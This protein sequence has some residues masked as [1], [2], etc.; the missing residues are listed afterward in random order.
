MQAA[1]AP[2][3]L[4]AGQQEWLFGTCSWKL[5]VLSFLF[6]ECSSWS[7]L[8]AMWRQGWFHISLQDCC[9]II[10]V[11]TW[12]P[13]E[14]DESECGRK[15]DGGD[16]ELLLLLRLDVRWA[17]GRVHTR[18][19]LSWSPEARRQHMDTCM[20][21]CSVIYVGCNE[22]QRYILLKVKENNEKPRKVNCVVP[23]SFIWA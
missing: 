5:K 7:E 3:R 18:C 1:E 17:S 20:E 21:S 4:S 19:S 14:H 6:T 23:L 13:G 8:Q 16:G 9:W 22:H 12:R 2:W 11:H 15:G 10:S